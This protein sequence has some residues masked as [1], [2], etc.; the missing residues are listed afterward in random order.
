MLVIF[1]SVSA[2]PTPKQGKSNVYCALSS[3]PVIVLFLFA[4]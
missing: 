2:Y 4:L 3:T 1:M